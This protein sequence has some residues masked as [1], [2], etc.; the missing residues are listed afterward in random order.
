[1]KNSINNAKR[2][3]ATTQRLKKY[4]MVFFDISINNNEVVRIQF[5]LFHNTT[6]ITADNFKALCT[7]EDGFVYQGSH[8]H[9]IIPEYLIQG[10]D[11]LFP[12]KLANTM[13]RPLTSKDDFIKIIDNITNII[14]KH[15]ENFEHTVDAS[16]T[17]HEVIEE[18][19]ER[20]IAPND[21]ELL[22][23][24]KQL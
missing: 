13:D 5:E 8:F 3:R 15:L 22:K 4:N 7:S 14:V 6:P 17:L 21:P 2:T 12:R 11:L 9:R 24:N 10:K 18:D 1:M 16:V 23:I 19:K 20:D